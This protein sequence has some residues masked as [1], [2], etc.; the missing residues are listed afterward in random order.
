MAAAEKAELEEQVALGLTDKEV[1]QSEAVFAAIAALGSDENAIEKTEIVTAQGGDFKLYELIDTE[2]AGA[3]TMK[4]WMN[5][6]RETYEEKSNK[7]NGLIQAQKWLNKMLK[8]MSKNLGKE[9]L[10]REIDEKYK[11]EDAPVEKAASA[12]DVMAIPQVEEASEAEAAPTEN[13]AANENATCTEENATCTEGNK[14]SLVEQAAPAEQAVLGAIQEAFAEE[15][16]TESDEAQAAPAERSTPAQEAA[17]VE[18]EKAA[19]EAAPAQESNTAPVEEA[20][21]A[22]LA[23]PTCTEEAALAAIREALLADSEESE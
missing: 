21:A 6:I 17:P 11:V 3:V 5:Y 8:K 22:D 13:D 1:A 23:A 2:N 20:K 4:T 9:E 12:K 18:K 19:K 15:S 16:D 10:M 7:T 14:A